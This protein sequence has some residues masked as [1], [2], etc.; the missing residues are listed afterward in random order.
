MNEYDFTFQGMDITDLIVYL[1]C[2]NLEPK[3]RNALFAE[4]LTERFGKE[5]NDQ[6]GLSYC[7]ALMSGINYAMRKLV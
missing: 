1:G 4:K 2:R 6:D 7:F 5:I 3:K